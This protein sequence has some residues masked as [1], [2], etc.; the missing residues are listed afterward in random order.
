MR[1]Y[2]RADFNYRLKSYLVQMFAAHP[3]I[4]DALGTRWGMKE[5][6]DLSADGVRRLLYRVLGKFTMLSSEE[7][8][9]ELG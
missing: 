5:P 1:I 8:M 4:L 6:S 9:G 7:L 3:D 2:S